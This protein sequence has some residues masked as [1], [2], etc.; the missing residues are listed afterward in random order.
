MLSLCLQSISANAQTKK[1]V[2]D[3]TQITKAI[4]IFAEYEGCKTELASTKQ[5]LT[6]AND[7]L[8][9]NGVI[10]KL[11]NQE[12]KNKDNQAANVAA[13]QKIKDDATEANT[14]KLKKSRNRGW[15][16]AGVAILVIVVKFVAGSNN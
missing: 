13:Q 15:T 6:N 16:V 5:L 11:K 14:T 8:V 7:N 4:V 3:S 9:Q 2:V 1:F 12:L 10:I